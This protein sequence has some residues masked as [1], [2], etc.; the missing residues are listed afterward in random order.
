MVCPLADDLV[1]GVADIRQLVLE[2]VVATRSVSI[3]IE[4][5]SSSCAACWKEIEFLSVV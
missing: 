3:F 4:H 1:A 2:D 5:D